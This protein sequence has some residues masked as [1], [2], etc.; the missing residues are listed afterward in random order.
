MFYSQSLLNQDIPIG[1]GAAERNR[2]ADLV[3]EIEDEIVACSC[4]QEW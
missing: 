3:G 4:F 1:V 2:K